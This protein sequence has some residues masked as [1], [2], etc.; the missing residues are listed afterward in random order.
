MNK[1]ILKENFARENEEKLALQIQLE[2]LKKD[3]EKD[4]VEQG[5]LEKKNSQP[6]EREQQNQEN[7]AVSVPVASAELIAAE[8]LI[9]SQRIQIETMTME[10]HA[11][12][13]LP[14]NEPTL[15][16]NDPFLRP[17]PK[18]A[19]CGGCFPRRRRL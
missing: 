15:E 9:Q 14:K 4:N 8:N 10:L 16:N 11:L 19:S 12:R 13:S 6:E 18:A 7:E 3:M 5:Q 1:K 17:S 2:L